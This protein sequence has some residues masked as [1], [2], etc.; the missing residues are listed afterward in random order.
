MPATGKKRRV[1]LRDGGRAR[2]YERPRDQQ[3]PL[4]CLDEFC[5]Q[6]LAPARPA[7]PTQPGAPARK[8]YE[9]V[10][11]GMCSAF[12][13][14]SPLEGR[15]KV[16]VSGQRTAVEYALTIRWLWDE[17]YPQAEK[18][19][20]VQDNLNTHGPASLYEAFPPQ[21]AI[22]ASIFPNYVET[23]NE[24]TYRCDHKGLQDCHRN[25]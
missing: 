5:K 21:E 7:V 25:R 3:R 17:V 18:I 20:L 19:V 13:I 9:Y 8:D 23:P 15:Q 14:Y 22:T 4:V 24:H 1:C 16:R 12:M 6:L 11:C 2:V 10:R